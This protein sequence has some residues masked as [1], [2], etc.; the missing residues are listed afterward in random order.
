MTL[1]PSE[2]L[3]RLLS[4]RILVFDSAMGTMIQSFK[5]DEADFR[6][7]RHADHPQDLKGCL[8][9]LSLTRPDIIEEI[10]RVNMQS[11]AD[12]LETNTFNANAIS[13][14]DYGLE[15]EV[16]EINMAAAKIA[17]R[18]ADEFTKKEPGQPR[19]VAGS[20]GP[21]NRTA[22]LSPDVSD[23][24]YRNVTFEQLRDAYYEQARGL[25]DGGVDILLPETSFDTLNMK[26]ALFAIQ[27]LF[28]E[29]QKLIPLISSVTVVDA[30]GRTLSGQT[31]EAFWVSVSHAPLLAIGINCA[32][33]PATMRPYVEELAT[34][35]N[36]YVSCVPNAGLPN[37]FGEYDETPDQMAKV[38]GEFAREG[39]LNFAG[40]CC[41][42][43]PDHVR[44][45][46]DAVRGVRP[47][48]PSQPK[49]LSRYNGLEPL[50]IRPESSFIVIGERTNVTGSRKFA[51]LVKSGDYEAAIEVARGQVEGGANIL[52]VNMDEAL[53]DSEEVMRTF[54]NL[55]AMEP[56]IARLPI[57]IDSSKFS[58]IEEGLKCL[59]GK[60]IVNS[61]SLK[62]GEQKFKEQA[63]IIR[64]Y[65][66][67]VVV[68]AFDEQGQ[69]TSV[70]RKVEI[71][72]RAYRIL[73]K[74]VGFPPQDLIFDPNVLTVATGI[75]EHNEYAR[76][77]IDATRL[78]KQR[79]PGA[80]VSGGIS[81]LS[82]SF[83][84]NNFVRE[85]MNS[86]FLYHA[87]HAGLDM[88]IVNAGQLAVYDEIPI[89]ARN[90]IE[91][92]LFNR[93][94]EGTERLIHFAQS[95]AG[96]GKSREKDE[97]W[98][99]DPIDQRLSHSLVEGIADY[100]E[101]DA[102][103]AR[104][105]HGSPLAVIEGPLM[106]GMNIV[107][108]L[109]GS[110]KMFLPQV[111]KSA[112][113]MKKAVAYLQP[114]MEADKQESAASL[115]RGK[116]LFATVK[117][118]V[119]DIGK[120]IVGVVLACNGYKVIDLGVMVPAEKI[121]ETA[122]K[123]KVDIIGLSGLI[124]P[125]LD[126][127]VHVASE[128]ERLRFKVPLLI[129]GATTSRKHTAVRI[130]PAYSQ[131]TVHV[132]DASR[133]VGVVG[134]L[135]N[136]KSRSDLVETNRRDQVTLR[137]EF[138]RGPSRRLIS[139]DEA[140]RNSIAIDWQASQ[141]ATPGFLGT[142]VLEDI[143]L[144]EIVPYID[145]SPFFHA[146]EL[147]GVFPAILDKPDVG[148]AARE[149]FENAERLLDEIVAEKLLQPRAVY[150]FFPAQAAGDDILL[151]SDQSRTDELAR[152]H[153]LRQQQVKRDGGGYAALADFVAPGDSGLADYLGA[154][155]LTAGHG[156]A[157]LVD[158]FE[159]DHDDYHAIMVKALADRLAEALAEKL[160]QQARK[161]CGFGTE[162]H[163]SKEDLIRERYRGIRPAPGYPASPDHSEKATLFR[164]LAAQK[165]A[166]I[167]LTENFAM[168]PAASVSGL[169]F[170][171]PEARYFS[172]GRVGEDQVANY[173]RRK[174]LSQAEV[175]RW[176]GPHL[177]YDP[178]N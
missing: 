63:A 54:L 68:M 102:E 2:R 114:F 44:A 174:G 17:R 29:R 76:A 61:I 7:Q 24:A 72:E 103:E 161:D 6:G 104:Q 99:N 159:K 107:G 149:L 124:T 25:L 123:K 90:L 95:N 50:T 164:I 60:G 129:G 84:G 137:E 160:H 35:S 38:L 121:L 177:G 8:D 87:I 53:L 111:V 153:S 171:H 101:Q 80:K 113:V 157:E 20:M 34:V 39:W 96:P 109:F 133:A 48:V 127:M 11:G 170:N 112:R 89:E 10:H 110:G 13:M 26:A 141:I 134:K 42:S 94:P 138:E 117:G 83:R 75:E 146:W 175:E 40:G 155:A 143:P 21:T 79:C 33:G 27:Q 150:G 3:E 30:S 139:Y 16:Y 122:K 173:A 58:V 135:M 130:A 15:S 47:H 67:A 167:Q 86:A 147:R 65:G 168:L 142:R 178:R 41:G 69:A 28:A 108:D 55:L 140:C 37:A 152:F 4:E 18:V 98:R 78:L 126:E 116:L 9:I 154:F 93:S 73:T 57:M 49:P 119:H 32:L 148:K 82:F 172:V 156:A 81:N 169:Y 128:M 92:V 132:L 91:D 74:E 105:A 43:T 62:E 64:R 176:L 77:F 22:S 45:I 70:D 106:D 1:S 56:D 66:A 165:C 131:G 125:S 158:R 5:L 71:L 51:R 151:F 162:E 85:A 46:A 59:Q 166:G 88:G 19:F 120:N 31:P 97:A 118:D 12:I 23:P 14:S 115:D 163:L 136:P 145:W 144:D 52:D 100:I 36:I